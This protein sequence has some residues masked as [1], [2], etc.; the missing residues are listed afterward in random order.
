MSPWSCPYY[1]EPPGRNRLYERPLKRQDTCSSRLLA[2][3]SG[4]LKAYL[5]H[6]NPDLE[7]L[8]QRPKDITVKFGI[9][10]K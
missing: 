8:F 6:L 10:F 3:L 1:E 4:D 2:V 7:S 9:F 5:S